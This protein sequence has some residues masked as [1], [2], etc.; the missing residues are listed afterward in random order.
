MHECLKCEHVASIWW[1]LKLNKK[2]K[3]LQ[4]CQFHLWF[5]I[6][7]PD[8]GPRLSETHSGTTVICFFLAFAPNCA[9]PSWHCWVDLHWIPEESSEAFSEATW[10]DSL[11][12][13]KRASITEKCICSGLVHRD[14]RP[15]LMPRDNDEIDGHWKG[16]SPCTQKAQRGTFW[17]GRAGWC[18]LSP[19]L[20]GWCA[21]SHAARNRFDK[22]ERVRC[23]YP[24]VKHRQH[25]RAHPQ[26]HGCVHVCLIVPSRWCQLRQF[27]EWRMHPAGLR[28][29]RRFRL[30]FG[31]NERKKA[32]NISLWVTFPRGAR[33][34][35][36]RLL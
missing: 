3:R 10:A 22:L 35:L 13:E 20:A 15:V 36:S 30:F 33:G 4:I 25:V 5:V 29:R 11:L 1:N 7:P 18:H 8:S 24:S 14:T 31:K 9:A 19:L 26:S 21:L 12:Y 16:W 32:D 6:I 27:A 28:R 34:V 2:A 23:K 17:F